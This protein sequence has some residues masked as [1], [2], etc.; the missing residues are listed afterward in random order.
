MEHQDAVARLTAERYLLDEMTEAER[1]DYEEHY[2]SC[3]ECAEDV[4]LGVMMTDAVRTQSRLSPPVTASRFTA[5]AGAR[6]TW[7]SW[8]LVGL[9]AAAS[10]AIVTGYQTLIVVP[11]LRRDLEP[12]AVT[13][14]ALRSPTRGAATVL[15][16]D[17]SSGFVA[18]SI[19][20]EPAPAG[21]DV[22]YALTRE[23][24]EELLSGRAATPVPGTPLLLLVPTRMLTEPGRYV[25]SLRG[26]SGTDLGDRIFV[27]PN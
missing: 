19:D 18:L 27:V 13:P 5:D 16:V 4:R 21:G 23:R 26:S 24:G 8:N 9:A 2:F 12:R 6:R 17:R 15:T 22:Q 7:A 10:L 3:P 25:L 11:G 20:L 1:L 14:F